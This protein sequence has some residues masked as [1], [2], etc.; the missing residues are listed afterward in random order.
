MPVDGLIKTLI[1][2]RNDVF[3]RQPNQ[4]NISDKLYSTGPNSDNED[5]RRG[6]TGSA[7]INT[8]D[9]REVY[10]TTTLMA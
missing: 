1:K 5:R 9:L 8:I 10:K 7:A 6:V 3:I 4:I 2:Q